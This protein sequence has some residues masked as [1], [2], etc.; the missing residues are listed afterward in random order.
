MNLIKKIIK[1]NNMKRYFPIIILLVSVFGFNS[2]GKL[3]GQFAYKVAGMD[4]YRQ[5][6]DDM[7]FSSDSPV[8]WV[9]AFDRAF[10]GQFNLQ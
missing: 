2:C 4:T 7:E 5:M 9:F 1:L 3:K 10:P 8:D 6:T